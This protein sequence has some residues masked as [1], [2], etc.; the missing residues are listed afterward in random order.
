MDATPTQLKKQNILLYM[1]PRQRL[2]F[3]LTNKSQMKWLNPIISFADLP[4]AEKIVYITGPSR[5]DLTDDI[6]VEAL[7]KEFDHVLLG[8]MSGLPD[9]NKNKR[10][11]H[12]LQELIEKRLCDGNYRKLIKKTL[13]KTYIQYLLGEKKSVARFINRIDNP[14]I[15]SQ[16]IEQY[17]LLKNNNLT[18]N[19]KKKWLERIPDQHTR[20]KTIRT[21]RI[22]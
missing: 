4:I 15:K 5:K 10:L 14:L 1:T 12:K 20:N 17:L 18:P 16:A 19:T 3:A 7:S 13:L 8:L 6:I 22:S 2:T 11:K 21:I 9:N